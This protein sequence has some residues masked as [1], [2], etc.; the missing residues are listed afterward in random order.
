MDIPAPPGGYPE[1]MAAAAPPPPPGGY[2][3]E[4]SVA[5]PPPP[6]GYPISG[7]PTGPDRPGFMGGLADV[8]SS[9]NAGVSQF[10][11]GT[12][13]E[14]YKVGLATA[15]DTAQSI[16]DTARSLAENTPSPQ[17]AQDQA[18]QPEGFFP[19]VGYLATHPRLLGS[20]IASSLPSSAPAIVTTP[21]GALAGAAV[22]GVVG[23]PVGAVAGAGLGAKAG[24]GVGS[25]LGDYGSQFFQYLVDSGVDLHDVGAVERAISDPEIW[26]KLDKMASLHAGA[27]GVFDALGA[28]VGGK[29]VE[30]MVEG[31]AEGTSKRIARILSAAGLDAVAGA[32]GEATGELLAE[33]KIDPQQVAAEFF[34]GGLMSG[35]SVGMPIIAER[36][37]SKW[38]T[39][40]GAALTAIPEGAPGVAGAGVDP[41]AELHNTFVAAVNGTNPAPL[42]AVPG[43]TILGAPLPTD[44]NASLPVAGGTI[45]GL[46]ANGFYSAVQQLVEKSPSSSMSGAQWLATIKNT[47]GIKAEEV[48]LLGLNGFMGSNG[49]ISKDELLAHIADNQM[50][51]EFKLQPLDKAYAAYMPPGAS[52]QYQLLFRM[53]NISPEYMGGHFNDIN[54]VA[55]ALVGIYSDPIKGPI[56][57]LHEVQSDLHKDA[58]EGGY[59]TPQRLRDMVETGQNT[60]G[61]WW[62]KNKET[63]VG[64]GFGYTAAGGFDSQAT[65]LGIANITFGGVPAAPFRT[66]YADVMFKRV[67]RIA[68]DAGLNRLAWSS[69]EMMGVRYAGEAPTAMYKNTL[70]KI[71]KKF[72]ERY[73]VEIGTAPITSY[74]TEIMDSSHTAYESR[75]YQSEVAR[76]GLPYLPITNEMRTAVQQGMPIFSRPVDPTVSVTMPATQDNSPQSRGMRASAVRAAK[77]IETIAKLLGVKANLNFVIEDHIFSKDANGNMTAVNGYAQ[78]NPDGSYT[79]PISMKNPK[80]NGVSTWRRP[81]EMFATFAHEFGHIVHYTIYRDA[82]PHEK[83]AIDADIDMKLAD[84]QNMVGNNESFGAVMQQR[85]NAVS[86]LYQLSGNRRKQFAKIIPGIN[87]YWIS[88]EEIFAEQV[89]RFLTTDAKP[90]SVV[91]KF[92]SALGKKVRQAVALVYKRLGIGAVQPEQAIANWLSSRM[93]DMMPYMREMK[94]VSDWQAKIENFYNM[95]AIGFQGNGVPPTASTVGSRSATWGIFKGDVPAEVKGAAAVADHFNWIHKWALGLVQVAKLNP[96]LIPLQIYRELNVFFKNKVAEVHNI[97]IDTLRAWRK[98]GTDQATKVSDLMQA[99][100]NF[101]YLTPAEM[102]KKITRLPTKAEMVALSAKYGVTKEG[103]DVFSKVLIDFMTLL[104]KYRQ[105][106]VQNAN[107]IVDPLKQAVKLEAIDK[108]FK[109]L[110]ERPYV[111]GLHFG[112]YLVKVVDAAGH[113]IRMETVESARAQRQLAARLE[114]TKADP[115]HRV[116]A[117]VWAKDSGPLRGLPPHILELIADK[118]QLSDTQRADLD[119]IIYE[120]SPNRNFEA[121]LKKSRNTPGYSDDF[122][123]VYADFF[124][125]GATHLAR[126]AYQGPLEEQIVELEKASRLTGIFDRNKTSRILAYVQQHYQNLLNPKSDAYALK[127]ITFHWV[128][129]YNVASGLLNMTQTP[130]STYPYLASIFGDA[131]AVAHILMA[132]TQLSTYYRH[133]TIDKMTGPL[134]EALS[135][136]QQDG[137]LTEALAPELARQSQERNLKNFAKQK[138]NDL[139]HGFLG[140]SAAP[141]Q[142]TEKMNRRVAFRA[143]FNLAMANP[144]AKEVREVKLTNPLMYKELVDQGKD[145]KFVSAYLVAREAVEQTQGVYAAYAKP[146][147][148]QGKVGGIFMFK[149]FV[150][151]MLV[152]NWTHPKMAIRT[153]LVMGLLGGLMGVPGAEDLAALMK[154]MANLFFGKD[155]DLEKEARRFVLDMFGGD[156]K[157]GPFHGS[158]L[159]THGL[160]RYGFGLPAL[161]DLMGLPIPNVDMS[162]SVGFGQIAPVDV[163]QLLG[164]AGSKDPNTVI[165]E[166]SKQLAGAMYGLGFTLYQFLENNTQPMSSMRR[167]ATIMPH[168]MRNLWRAA[169][170]ARTGG[171]N[172]SRGQAVAKFD[173]RDP[174]DAMAMIA[175]ALGGLPL[176]VTAQWGQKDALAEALAY[177]SNTKLLLYNQMDAAIQSNDKSQIGDVAA[178]IRKFNMSLPE[179]AKP[180][181]I[182]G[183]ELNADM[184]DRARTRALK[185]LNMAIPQSAIPLSQSLQKLYPEAQPIGKPMTVK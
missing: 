166:Q 17:L 104:D 15:K 1:T 6:G 48:E 124:F 115:N 150:Q 109:A 87:T 108:Q 94:M 83:A 102:V 67:L 16:T 146:R 114:K 111:P 96:R 178:A 32:G 122:R 18:N 36:L 106:A 153:F 7:A 91:E 58:I 131:K 176:S 98:L 9:F 26:H 159:L 92:Y 119:D 123:R 30:P 154:A 132:S 51:V 34:I 181:A 162:G 19:N 43:G 35:A 77:V 40:K 79:I 69:P 126:I 50:T 71:A 100:K 61:T 33:G 141:M 135:L 39:P 144:S 12:Q 28:H 25:A 88:K 120:A 97:A 47:P 169:D 90:L 101:E 46:E 180:Q 127:A 167:W 62:F 24:I 133:A 64:G 143:A 82:S 116:L 70:P 184:K 20:E 13:I 142:L 160:S 175:V 112:Q 65:A 41:E 136:A 158:D 129:G 74:A 121:Q 147:I 138:T 75:L 45:P 128:M 105:A 42:P 177:Y 89:A 52:K 95:K 185:N 165:A 145:P 8:G 155:F 179:A 31:L 182:K 157:V 29:I 163:G 107:R 14:K 44:G 57:V 183:S 139:W 171:Y 23:G 174:E 93:T 137:T 173:V 164:P 148:F 161:G 134:F 49:K 80:P 4:A 110:A 151:Q 170:M 72:A 76:A 85:T 103:Y 5:P 125:H 86:N 149:S 168:E 118:M 140:L 172:D 54:V 81:A 117:R 99:Y 53:P 55:H 22:G 152:T 56:M 59:I 63:G 27:V 156:D 66:N 10:A 2:P 38:L 68:A 113:T 21:V 84:L 11:V 60:D 130:V 73:G 3:N 37:G 78:G